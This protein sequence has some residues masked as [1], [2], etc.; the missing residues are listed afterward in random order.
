MSLNPPK[1]W[2]AA[3]LE[4]VSPSPVH[5]PSPIIIP[6]LQHQADVYSDMTL[7]S[8]KKMNPTPVAIGRMAVL[9]DAAGAVFAPSHKHDQSDVSTADPYAKFPKSGKTLVPPTSGTM[10][11]NINTEI[12]PDKFENN[13]ADTPRAQETLPQILQTSDTSST[14]ALSANS[15]LHDALVPSSIQPANVPTTDLAIPQEGAMVPPPGNDALPQSILRPSPLN[16]DSID[17]QA[18]VDKITSQSVVPDPVGKPVPPNQQGTLTNTNTLAS[19]YT[20]PQMSNQ[21]TDLSGF[22]PSHTMQQVPNAIYDP[23]MPSTYFPNPAV[24]TTAPAFPTADQMNAFNLSSGSLGSKCSEV[25]YIPA[26]NVVSRSSTGS[27]DPQKEKW[28]SFLTYER[29]MSDAKCESFPEGSRIFVGNLSS[30]RVTKKEVFD[31]FSPYGRLAQISF[32][33]GYGFV[34]YHTAVEGRAAVDGLQGF[35][36]KGRKLNLAVSKGQRRVR[37]GYGRGNKVRHNQDQNDIARGQRDDYRPNQQ[38][39]PR[40]GDQRQRLSYDGSSQDRSYYDERKSSDRGRS[41]SPGYRD[42][43][44]SRI[45][46]PMP[47]HRHSSTS[48]VEPPRRVGTDVP[49]VQFFLLEEVEKDFITWAEGAFITQGLT[50]NVM[51]LDPRFARDAVIQRQVVDGVHAIAEL[52]YRSQQLGKI[53]LQVFDRSAGRNNVRYDQYQ[54]LDP[55]IAAQLVGRVKAQSQLKVPSGNKYYTQSSR[56]P[57]PPRANFELAGYPPQ[58]YQ[59]PG[60]YAGPPP[61]SPGSL[62]LD[63][64]TIQAIA[65]ALQGQQQYPTS[66]A[67]TNSGPPVDVHAILAALS[68]SPN[69][70]HAQTSGPMVSQHQPRR[71]STLPPPPVPSQHGFAGG[72]YNQPSGDA[73]QYVRDTMSRLSQFGH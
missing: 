33:H 30:D 42:P 66:L 60:Q 27:N 56:L 4:P 46:S 65:A 43:G 3:H 19:S 59:P 67:P 73:E 2:A 25:G 29:R 57:P 32:K 63:P 70:G 1:A 18:L 53:P 7:D 34:Q 8:N 14:V 39:S 52:N 13:E 24:Y 58:S 28:D 16:L 17:I 47:S 22:V 38:L 68:P 48:D 36:I 20:F 23:T 62:P 71:I 21:Q 31:L 55:S 69:G 15:L 11:A 54:D 44:A 64:N 12:N 51:F 5:P 49:D 72:H 6:T 9:N 61:Q 45:R 50:V 26:R 41:R 35:E 10:P 40:R 37:D